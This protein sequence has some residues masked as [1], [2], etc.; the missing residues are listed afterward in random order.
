M[1]RTPVDIRV[2]D[3][4][5]TVQVP[6]LIGVIAPMHVAGV[7]DPE[8]EIA[9]AVTHPIGSKRLCAIAEGKKTAAIV[10]ND[11]TRPYPGGLM[12]LEIARELNLGGIRDENISLIVAYGN[13]RKNTDEE[14]CAQYGEDVIHRFRVVHHVATDPER[15]T[16]L[17]ETRSGMPVQLNKEFCEADVKILTGLIAPHQLAGFS[18]GRKSVMP[19]IAGIESLKRHH[20]FPIRPAST[21]CGWLE[22]NAFHEE[23]MEAA[24]IAGVDFI[25]NSVDNAER[26]LVT[27]AA[28]D[29]EAAYLYGVEESRKIWTVTIPRRPDVVIVSP[30]GFPRDFDLH[31]S[32]KSIGCAEMICRKGGM[33]ILCA[34][35]RDGAGKPGKVLKEATSAQEVIDRFVQNG[36]SPDSVSKAYMLARASTQFTV[37]VA[38]SKIPVEELD[39]M[40]LEGYT[41][42]EKAIESALSRYGE[43]A[44]FMVVP[45]ASEVIPLIE[46]DISTTSCL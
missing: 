18:G 34:E 16:Y 35:A 30:G 37:A 22:G 13:H 31:Q 36:Y 20:S 23:A 19:G 26:E 33:I 17:G 27:C 14:L 43:D 25:V 40:F 10:I 8:S 3:E 9:R 44:S 6:N 32:Q 42:I 38:Q 2:G 29:L 4:T 28:G 39:T 45:H 41:S 24:R 15:L 1:D 46:T 12:V 5:Y 21:S 11:I 7:K